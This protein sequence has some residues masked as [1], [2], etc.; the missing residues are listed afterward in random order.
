MLLI[1]IKK[2]FNR[3]LT[4]LFIVLPEPRKMF[5]GETIEAASEVGANFLITEQNSGSLNSSI[6]PN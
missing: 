1:L 5:D 6:E 3:T 2:A 4:F